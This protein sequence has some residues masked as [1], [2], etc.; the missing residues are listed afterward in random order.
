MSRLPP[1][2]LAA[3]S[4]GQSATIT[5]LALSERE[6][7]WLRAVGLGE[8]VGVTVLR[9]APFGGPLHVRTGGGAE[10]AVDRKL[11]CHLT[12]APGAPA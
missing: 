10:L 9:R 12:V 8:G 5:A 4:P 1:S 3:L 2:S 11:A 6:A 7:G